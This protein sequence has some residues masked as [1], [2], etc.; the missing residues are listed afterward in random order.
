M[1]I[2]HSAKFWVDGSF[3]WLQRTL[4]Q[5]LVKPLMLEFDHGLGEGNGLTWQDVSQAGE[6]LLE[7]LPD[8]LLEVNIQARPLF[9]ISHG[10]GGVIVKRV[11]FQSTTRKGNDSS[12][13]ALGSWSS[14]RALL[15]GDQLPENRWDLVWRGTIELTTSHI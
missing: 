2:S 7:C 14:L 5:I 1:G 9:F 10:L 4:P 12:S 6:R 13:L 8:K 11:S 15:Q 3:N